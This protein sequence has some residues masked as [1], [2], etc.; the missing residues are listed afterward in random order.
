MTFL[1]PSNPLD[2]RPLAPAQPLAHAKVLRAGEYAAWCEA[3]D[4]IADARA[5]AERILAESKQAFDKECQRGFEQGERRAKQAQ[6]EAMIDIV[7]RKV[8][9]LEGVEHDVIALVMGAVR[10]VV[11]GFDDEAKVVAVTRNALAVLRNQKQITLRLHP[12]QLDYA[13]ANMTEFL[14]AFPGIG[15]IDLVGDERLAVGSC[16]LESIIGTVE[17]SLDDQITA[18]DSAFKRVLG[19][20]K[21]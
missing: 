3:R 13:K 17:A 12:D 10:K 18:L 2:P 6:T 21:G 11:D 7:S 20:R 19:N 4:L 5:Q 1:V 9:Y 15:F 8:D 14:T 16:I